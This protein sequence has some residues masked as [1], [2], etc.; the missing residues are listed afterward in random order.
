MNN[1][2]A[3]QF[4]P[5][6]LAQWQ[7]VTREYLFA[8]LTGARGTDATEETSRHPVAQGRS[9]RG[10]LLSWARRAL[11]H[12]LKRAARDEEN[13]LKV[14]ESGFYFHVA[15]MAKHPSVPATILAWHAQTTDTR[16]RTR[17][18]SVI[19][20]YEKRLSRLIGRAKQ[21]GLVKPGV[22][23]QTAAA[24]LVGLIQS[25]A[26]RMS[27][28]ISRPETLLRDAATVFPAYLDGIL[29]APVRVAA[30]LFI[31]RIFQQEVTT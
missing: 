18:R 19:S 20:H 9:G 13:P 23:A 15:L 1:N 26:L 7:Q 6:H 2:E 8:P 25:L 11:L 10:V 17:I 29:A 31:D 12:L 30:P 24:V 28:G 14:L 21:Q 16:I 4:N 27:T 3:G 22:D 5:D